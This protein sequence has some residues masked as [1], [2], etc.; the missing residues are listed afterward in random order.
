MVDVCIISLNNES[1][2]KVPNIDDFMENIIPRSSNASLAN[3]TY[4]NFTITDTKNYTPTISVEVNES[5]NGLEIGTEEFAY[6]RDATE[7][8]SY[9]NAHDDNFDDNTIGPYWTTVNEGNGNIN[10]DSGSLSITSNT[11]VDWGYQK[12]GSIA[13]NSPAVFQRIFGDF[14]LNVELGVSGITAFKSAG[15][16]V[17]W[18][19]NFFNFVFKSNN[20]WCNLVQDGKNKILKYHN[21]A[22]TS[23]LWLKIV[24]GGNFFDMYYSDDG[25]TYHLFLN[26]M[27]S[28]SSLA[29]VGIYSAEG[30]T[31]LVNWWEI[32]PSIS[33]TQ[34]GGINSTIEETIVI[35]EIPFKNWNEGE[36]NKV[37]LKMQS[38]TLP[39]YSDIYNV[40]LSV[41]D[42]ILNITT[43]SQVSREKA[44]LSFKSS[45]NL[46]TPQLAMQGT[47][48]FALAESQWPV[49]PSHD[50]FIN[51]H[52]DDFL[53]SGALNNFWTILN[54]GGLLYS[55]ISGI[56]TVTDTLNTIL[57]E[58]TFTAPCMTQDIKGNFNFSANFMNWDNIT[59][60]QEF[61]LIILEE[62]NPL[63]K[64]SI[65]NDS[66][67]FKLLINKYAGGSNLLNFQQSI[68]ASSNQLQLE[69]R[70]SLNTTTFHYNILDS[71][72]SGQELAS[73]KID[74]NERY[75]VGFYVAQNCVVS[76][77]KWFIS[78]SIAVKED[79]QTGDLS[80]VVE[81]IQ[82]M[83]TFMVENSIIL[84]MNATNGSFSTGNIYR[85]DVQDPSWSNKG[86]L[87]TY[88][89]ETIILDSAGNIL[90]SKM[91]FAQ[92][93]VEFGRNHVFV[94]TG[95][96][97]EGHVIE[98]DMSGNIIKDIAS[99]GGIPLAWPHDA[100]LLENGNLL[101]TDSANNRVIE[102]NNNG[103]VGWSWYVWDYLINNDPSLT[104][105]VND[106]DRLPNGNTLI[107]IRNLDTVVEVNPVG[108]IVWSYGQFAP[109]GE[110]NEQHNAD[111]LKN[112]NTI[113]CDSENHRV[114]EVDFAGNLLWQYEP[115]GSNQVP[116]DWVR[117]ADVVDDNRVLISDT[118]RLLNENSRVFEI[119]KETGDIL[120]ELTMTNQ[121]YDADI[122]ELTP[123]EVNI[124]SPV[125]KT[126]GNSELIQVVLESSS[127]TDI[128][129]YKIR[130]NTINITIDQDP[131]LYTG[132]TSRLL[133]DNH[134][135][136][137]Y[138][139][140]E[141]RLA[142]SQTM[143][144]SDY[145]SLNQTNASSVNFTIGLS[146]NQ[147]NFDINDYQLVGFNEMSE[148]IIVYNPTTGVIEDFDIFHSIKPFTSDIRVNEIEV[149]ANKKVLLVA[150]IWFSNGSNMTCVMEQDLIND[151][152]WTYWENFSGDSFGFIDVDFVGC[153][154]SFMVIS[155]TN[156]T[157]FEIDRN[158]QVSHRWTYLDYYLETGRN[159]TSL[160]GNFLD[161]I[162]DF[163][164]NNT[165]IPIKG[166]ETIIIINGTRN[167]TWIINNTLNSTNLDNPRNCIM[168][169]NNSL[170]VLNGSAGQI[171]C[172]DN[173]GSLIWDSRNYSTFNTI[174]TTVFKVLPS[175]N[176][177][178]QDE[179]EQTIYE[180]TLSGSVISNITL[181][182]V[183]KDF[184][185]ILHQI[186]FLFISI[187]EN[188]TY[189]QQLLDFTI[190]ISSNQLENDTYWR[191]FNESS[192][193]WLNGSN[194]KNFSTTSPLVATRFLEDGRYSLEVI[195]NSTINAS[196]TLGTD[197]SS[198]YLNIPHAIF[199][200]HFTV[201]K[202]SHFAMNAPILIQGMLKK[203]EM[204]SA[205]ISWS[206][207]WN[208]DN[209]SIYMYASPITE[210]N[211]SV[212]F[213]GNTDKT[214]FI[215]QK[216]DIATPYIVVIANNAETT[217]PISNNVKIAFPSMDD[218][219]IMLTIIIVISIASIFL[220]LAYYK[221]VIVKKRVAA[222]K[223][224]LFSQRKEFLLIPAGQIMISIGFILYSLV[225]LTI[226]RILFAPRDDGGINPP[227]YPNY[228][229]GYGY[230]YMD[231]DLT[232]PGLEWLVL[233]SIIAVILISFGEFLAN[234]VKSKLY[235]N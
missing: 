24:R 185:I 169:D 216:G 158:Y 109:A 96:N 2:S 114:L 200:V 219:W 23:I 106:A 153:N 37:K 100:D 173:T 230:G 52:V 162:S 29:E 207:I 102:I 164:N 235:K 220:L 148:N 44:S 101:I 7:S 62:S 51:P 54:G 115:S 55:Q 53:I 223:K 19:T 191:V 21:P 182:F 177:L 140:A 88:G 227:G 221:L 18:G 45:L 150:D 146:S 10:E 81:G 27:F 120:W 43:I 137:L 92:L 187:P 25:S 179:N 50:A 14:E 149:I 64:F 49:V 46:T 151:E 213:I 69:I 98:Y 30:G 32:T 121:P 143:L 222:G 116:L 103:D 63:L 82:V 152:K 84:G 61:G 113:I 183:L 85:M 204:N 118:Q 1:T 91:D 76:I 57:N 128:I 58:S 17:K 110:L 139:W 198:F 107:S 203:S 167:I 142:P 170:Y 181:D 4:S 94:T 211:N 33:C 166:D 105:H 190:L 159:L 202:A 35:E 112:G 214:W 186:P 38:N 97:N 174:N 74:A 26:R 129:Y 131:I 147:S 48:C 228:D 65:K 231:F 122:V 93:D 79:I 99:V 20:L 134:S 196:N 56:L 163:G 225:Y 111:R 86:L 201:D 145:H 41:A 71:S 195:V 12:S 75:S 8:V 229:Y 189:Y 154:D 205:I 31:V 141:T 15:V 80:L 135:Y 132:I 117:D 208:A 199:T 78:P 89:Q 172:L 70:K 157:I 171:I 133:E 95:T 28:C 108:N 66:G 210:I 126:I 197:F 77:D 13:R 83:N 215:L 192:S 42:E 40:P 125:N 226:L 136:T 6:T 161:K 3:I 212:I 175:G 180:V 67:Q 87:F 165:L 22:I 59:G 184:E 90:F 73:L 206:H 60:N 72:E 127:P 176:L 119:N 232:A 68:N 217:S 209:Y 39:G 47:E 224:G 160:N 155:E 9:S 156:L 138:A 16:L 233:T 194:Y 144:G 168:L 123:P 124:L 11:G 218:F 130:D 178:L 36:E 34:N 234:F 5:T 188:T 104:S 193:T